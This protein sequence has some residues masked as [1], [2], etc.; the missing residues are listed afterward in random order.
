MITSATN[1]ICA[2]LKESLHNLRDFRGPV[3]LDLDLLLPCRRVLDG[4]RASTTLPQVLASLLELDVREVIQT[5][6]VRDHFSAAARGLGDYD[7]LL[8]SI[9]DSLEGVRQQKQAGE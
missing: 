2:D 1:L 8:G 4:R 6:D 7:F 9:D 3:A 5:H